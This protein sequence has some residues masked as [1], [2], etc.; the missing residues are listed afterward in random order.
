[1]WSL[2]DNQSFENTDKLGSLSLSDGTSD[3]DILYTGLCHSRGP[4][5]TSYSPWVLLIRLPLSE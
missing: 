1:M 2:V 3:T 4:S 5:H